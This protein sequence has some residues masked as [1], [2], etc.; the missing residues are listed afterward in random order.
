MARMGIDTSCWSMGSIEFW[1][2]GLW[3]LPV[4]LTEIISLFKLVLLTKRNVHDHVFHPPQHWTLISFLRVDFR[5][6]EL[7]LTNKM[8]RYLKC[9]SWWPDRWIECERIL[10][11]SLPYHQH[12]I[13]L[14]VCER[15]H[16]NSTSLQRSKFPWHNTVL[17]ASH[18][19]LDQ[20]PTLFIL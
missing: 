14:Y 7:S 1:W 20:L 8:V 19:V 6:I 12:N 5:F 2:V 4:L 13:Y 17:S 16:F 11:I 18:H 10:P 9:T 15:K 3:S